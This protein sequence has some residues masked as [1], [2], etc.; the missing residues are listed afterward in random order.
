MTFKSAEE[1]RQYLDNDFLECLICGAKKRGL[2]GHITSKHGITAKQYK[3]QFN[4]SLQDA[5]DGKSL[6]QHRSNKAKE[7]QSHL[8][9]QAKHQDPKPGY[10]NYVPSYYR[11][12]LA[13]LGK[14]TGSRNP[15]SDE[16][17]A[18]RYL[19]AWENQ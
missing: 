5:L 12:K 2:G 13:A 7:R 18:R 14:Q 3:Q 4:M 11:E 1:V 15:V 9:L 8:I 10:K 17:R 19:S 16:E 6:R